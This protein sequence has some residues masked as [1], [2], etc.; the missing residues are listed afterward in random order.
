MNGGREKTRRSGFLERG[1]NSG[2]FFQHCVE[3]FFGY[4]GLPG[5]GADQVLA[6]GS[7][8]AIHGN[9]EKAGAGLLDP[10]FVRRAFLV[11]GAEP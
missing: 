4:S 5:H 3:L 1:F 2:L 9:L 8:R 10:L 7:V 6:E 11:A